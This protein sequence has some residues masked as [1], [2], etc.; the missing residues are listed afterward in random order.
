M[1]YTR[2]VVSTG[3]LLVITPV[4]YNIREPKFVFDSGAHTNQGRKWAEG[5]L[6]EGPECSSCVAFE[7]DVDA[8]RIQ[9]ADVR[10]VGSCPEDKLHWRLAHGLVLVH[11]YRVRFSGS[12]FLL[13][14]LWDTFGSS[15]FER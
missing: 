4:A 1:V 13:H 6:P 14:I 3:V 7:M 8:E 12:L 15:S 2:T 10:M 11:V 9:A 5:C